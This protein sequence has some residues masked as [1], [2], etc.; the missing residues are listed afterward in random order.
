MPTLQNQVDMN[1]YMA[2]QEM[3]YN[4]LCHQVL[5]SLKKKEKKQIRHCQKSS[6]PKKSVHDSLEANKSNRSDASY[7]INKGDIFL[8]ENRTIKFKGIEDGKF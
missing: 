4:I 8:F 5:Q 2:L 1:K 6:L 7:K 3:I